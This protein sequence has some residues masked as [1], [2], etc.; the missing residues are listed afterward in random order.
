MLFAALIMF[1]MSLLIYCYSLVI[2]NQIIRFLARCIVTLELVA[3]ILLP[4]SAFWHAAGAEHAQLWRYAP[5]DP[6]AYALYEDGQPHGDHRL[7]DPDKDSA[8]PGT[9]GSWGCWGAGWKAP[10]WGGIT[11]VRERL[12][13][14]PL[15]DIFARVAVLV[16]DLLTRGAFLGA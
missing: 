2:E 1:V 15:R 8:W 3:I 10:T 5:D 7:L 13:F 4:L 14:E 6:G 12:G 9:L 11:R 16:A